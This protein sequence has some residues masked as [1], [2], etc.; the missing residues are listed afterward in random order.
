MAGRAGDGAGDVV[1]VW[2][3][4]HVLF[5]PGERLVDLPISLLL[6]TLTN[7]KGQDHFPRKHV[8]ESA[9]GPMI[10]AI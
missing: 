1:T 4:C 3:I 7:G 2:P 9:L 10:P 6:K 5:E 8:P